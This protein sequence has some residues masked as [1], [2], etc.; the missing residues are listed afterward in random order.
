MVASIGTR[1]RVLQNEGGGAIVVAVPAKIV[2]EPDRIDRRAERPGE[3]IAHSAAVF[4]FSERKALTRRYAKPPQT[5]PTTTNIV[6]QPE[7]DM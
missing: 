5:K 1:I 7:V 2:S 3:S 6:I 4:F